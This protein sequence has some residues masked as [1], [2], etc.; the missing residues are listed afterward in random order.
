MTARYRPNI[1]R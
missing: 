1:Y